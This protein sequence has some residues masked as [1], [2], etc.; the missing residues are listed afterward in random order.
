MDLRRHAPNALSGLRIALV[1]L[2]LWLAWAGYPTLLLAT[3]GFSLSTDLLD[4]YLARRFRSGSELGAKLDS[5][6]DLATYSA[7]PLCAWWAFREQVTAQ[8]PFAIAALVGFVTPTLIGLAKFR[9]ITSYHTRLAKAVAI[10]MGVGLILYLGFG[11]AGFFQAAVLFLLIEALEEVAITA[12]LPEWRANVPSFAAALRISRAAKPVLAVALA[13]LGGSNPAAAQAL[14]P[15]LRPE[16]PASDLVVE[17]DTNV[18]PGDVAEGC[19]ASTDHRDLVR[20]SLITRNDGPGSL[21]LGNPM[22][23]NCLLNPDVTCD[24]PLFF[25]SPAGGHDHAHYKNFLHYELIDANDAVAATGAK[26]GFCLEDTACDVGTH[27]SH[28]CE[29]QGL[30]AHCSD[31]YPYYLGCQYIDATDVPDGDYRVRVTVDPLDQI[32]EADETN[33]VIVTDTIV[34]SRVPPTEHTLDGGGLVLKA[35]HVLRV[36]ADS[37]DKLDFSI[38]GFDPTFDGATLVVTDTGSAEQIAF[39]LPA[40]GWKRV[41]KEGDP[42][43]FRYTGD[44]SDLDPCRAVELGRGGLRA[45]CSLTGDHVHIPL[46]AKGDLAVE[47]MLASGQRLCANFGGVTLRNDATQVKRRNAD[48]NGCT[49]D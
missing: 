43:A 32:P 26:L 21:D 3:F 12:V 7:F 8:L 10:V 6:G 13:L 44:G 34:I 2:L 5:W 27:A 11:V 18:D 23:P 15:D 42:R 39:G 20:L 1:P 4:G 48:P 29:D 33:N 14:L 37:V 36:K 46:P 28:T 30:T 35:A 40:S 41:G 9:R 17:Y 22:C 45:R 47:L 49:L 16:V 19:A 25:C 38:P 31:E 24:N